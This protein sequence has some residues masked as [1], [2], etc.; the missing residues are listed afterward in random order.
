MQLHLTVEE[1]TQDIG[2]TR[3]IRQVSFQIGLLH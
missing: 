1:L 3:G 2:L